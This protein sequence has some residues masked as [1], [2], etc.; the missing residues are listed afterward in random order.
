[1]P[2]ETGR[3]A[4]TH[5]GHAKG[6]EDALEDALQKMNSPKWKEGRHE[7]V[8]VTFQLDLEVKSPGHV[9]FYKVTVTG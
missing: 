2:Q 8:E 1:M 9:G 3:A 7:N 6:F 5:Q 4:M